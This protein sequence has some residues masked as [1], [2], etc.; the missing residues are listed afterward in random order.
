MSPDGVRAEFDP[1][2]GF[3]PAPDRHRGA[4][5]DGE[6]GLRALRRGEPRGSAEVPVA[7]FTLEMKLEVTQRLMCLRPR[8]TQRLR[9]GKCAG[10]L[11]P[12]D[13]RRDKLAMPRSTSTTPVDHADGDPLSRG[14]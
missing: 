1:T 8:S 14:G 9:T 2:S 7:M 6:V 5:V 13:G 4:P 12:A 11:A 3:R 10:G